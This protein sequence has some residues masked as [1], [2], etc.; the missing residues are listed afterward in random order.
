MTDNEDFSHETPTMSL[1]GR[2]FFFSGT[3]R[4]YGHV[5]PCIESHGWPD[6]DHVNGETRTDYIVLGPNDR[7]F[8]CR[9]FH[10][11]DLAAQ[12]TS[13]LEDYEEVT[14]LFDEHDVERP[15]FFCLG[16][17]GSFYARAENG[18]EKW[19][20]SAEIVSNAL[21]V[22]PTATQSGIQSLWLGVRG[23]WVAQ[24]RDGTFNFDL[25]GQYAGLERVLR[26]AL[27]E[28]VRIHGLAL[29][30]L[31]GTSYAC[32]L[33]D[34]LVQYEAGQA[35]FNGQEFEKWCEENYDLKD[36]QRLLAEINEATRNNRR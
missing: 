26:Q 10:K 36:L 4:S 9:R 31:D 28:E 16:P 15:A 7:F 21:Q 17:N 5:P 32:V 25:K 8:R 33:A 6:Y 24:Y 14:D 34:G 12:N 30:V 35:G 23:S 29:N 11:G 20:L 3:Y 22:T 1:C 18:A 2:N 19:N 13:D 27:E